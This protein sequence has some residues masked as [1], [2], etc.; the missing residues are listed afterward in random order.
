VAGKPA[1]FYYI[2]VEKPQNDIELFKIGIYGLIESILEVH[3][4]AVIYI[5][6]FGF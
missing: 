1:K 4:S 6:L 3:I 5:G 2:S